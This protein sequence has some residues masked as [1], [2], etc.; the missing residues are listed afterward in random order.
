MSDISPLDEIM[1]ALGKAT[2]QGHEFASAKGAD[3]IATLHAPDD[4][5]G[6]VTHHIPVLRQIWWSHR[7]LGYRYPA[8]PGRDI[9]MG[10]LGDE[11]DG[12]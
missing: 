8:E 2:S 4:I 6:E 11:D 3:D 5:G 1:S 12:P 9:A 7:G 10:E